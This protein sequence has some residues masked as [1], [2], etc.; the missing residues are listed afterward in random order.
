M[1]SMTI[2]HNSFRQKV[3]MKNNEICLNCGVRGYV[4]RGEVGGQVKAARTEKH[5]NMPI[6]K[7]CGKGGRAI[8]RRDTVVL[9]KQ[10]I[11][12]KKGQKW[13]RGAYCYFC[14]AQHREDRHN[15]K[16]GTKP[17]YSLP[18]R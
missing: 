9:N 3:A 4:S 14:D 8:L 5:A 18:K 7:S 10:I 13:F 1:N 17:I 12:T 2:H 11:W 15:R 16:L 6:K